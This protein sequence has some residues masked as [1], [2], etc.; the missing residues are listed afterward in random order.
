MT[1]YKVESTVGTIVVSEIV[2]VDTD[3]SPEDEI[4][5][6]EDTALRNWHHIFN[7]NFDLHADEI[8]TYAIKED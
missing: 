8:T 1:K 5:Y 2:D 4:N 6:A 3:L 7:Y